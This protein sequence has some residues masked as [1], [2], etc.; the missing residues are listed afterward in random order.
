MNERKKFKINQEGHFVIN[1]SDAVTLAEQFGTPLYVFDETAIRK[2]CRN[3]KNTLFDCYGNGMVMYASKAFSSLAIYG[4]VKQEGLGADVV[5]GGELYTALKAG[6]SPEYLVFHGNN[7]TVYELEDAVKAGIGLIVIDGFDEAEIIDRIA[8]QNGVKQNVLLRVNPGVEAHT[9][10]F[11]QTAKTDSKFGFA[12]SNGDAFK[13][14]QEII[15]YKNLKLLGLHCHIGSQIFEKDSFKIAAEK[16][17]SFY[18]EI[19]NKLGYEFSVLNLGGGFGIWYTDDDPVMT[20]SDYSEFIKIIA[21]TIKK[22]CGKLDLQLPFLY[23]EP[24]RSI[25]GEAG[26]TL[27]TAGQVREVIDV[28]NFIAIDGGM[29]ENPRYAL[30]DAKYTALVANKMNDK[31]VKNYSIVGKCCESGD[32]IIKEAFLPEV[33]RGDIIAVLSTG[34][35]NYSMA[36]HYNRNFIPPVV[37]VVP[38]NSAELIVKKETYDDLIARDVLPERLK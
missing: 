7:K 13:K 29:F 38:E 36:S 33:K 6:F 34:A 35:Y 1:N 28:R 3:L 23:L 32:I 8:G 37:L 14:I 21:E 24:G 17:L 4:I 18:S 25:V 27:Y 30:Y 20:E 12:I 2:M 15:E 26:V 10:E 5:S 22:C 9:H 19:K 16:M 11:I 31:P